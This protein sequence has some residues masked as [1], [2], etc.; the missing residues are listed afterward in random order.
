MFYRVVANFDMSS[1]SELHVKEF[2]NLDE[3]MVEA[4]YQVNDFINSI[5]CSGALDQEDTDWESY[6][7]L[8][9]FYGV[10]AAGEDFCTVTVAAANFEDEGK[11][12]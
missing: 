2:L 5:P 10:S 1:W 3:A 8:F 11:D 12:E 4:A 9:R 6:H 7:E